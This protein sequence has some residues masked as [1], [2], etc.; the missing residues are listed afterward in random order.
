MDNVELKDWLEKI[1]GKLDATII[2][3]TKT[4][5]RVNKLEGRID[6][7]EKV[8]WFAF[9]TIITIGGFIFQHW[10]SKS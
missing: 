2:Q 6:S 10:I 4:N 1:D 5:G 9:G 7:V 3:T 8:L